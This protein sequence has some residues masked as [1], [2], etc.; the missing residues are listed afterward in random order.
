MARPRPCASDGPTESPST[1][2]P[3][4]PHHRRRF[5]GPARSP[6]HWDPA[7]RA[8]TTDRDLSPRSPPMSADGSITAWVDRLKAGDSAA[9]GPLWQ[10]YFRRLVELARQ[11]LRGLS[12]AADEEDVALS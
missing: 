10:A 2:R 3:A 8:A 11:R 5:S 4:A 7:P 6:H 9:A 12:G 1:K